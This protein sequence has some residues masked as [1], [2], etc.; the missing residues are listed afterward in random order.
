M[1]HFDY[2]YYYLLRKKNSCC[3]ECEVVARWSSMSYVMVRACFAFFDFRWWGYLGKCTVGIS[4]I[5]PVQTKYLSR[6]GLS[7]IFSPLETRKPGPRFNA[8]AKQKAKKNPE[9]SKTKDDDDDDE[10]AMYIIVLSRKGFI[11]FR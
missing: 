11:Q 9:K 7:R 2:L 5:V 10:C 3:M 1:V 8:N 6:T 4:S